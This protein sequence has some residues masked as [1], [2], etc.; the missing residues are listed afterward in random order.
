MK[1]LKTNKVGNEQCEI[2]SRW[3]ANVIDNQKRPFC[4]RWK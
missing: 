1:T 2:T 4:K 3:V